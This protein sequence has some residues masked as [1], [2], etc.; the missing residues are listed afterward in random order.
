MLESWTQIME[1]DSYVDQPAEKVWEATISI[2]LEGKRL[3][4]IMF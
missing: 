3:A 4:V 1:R 2:W